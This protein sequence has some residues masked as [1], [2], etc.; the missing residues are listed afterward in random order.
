MP[1]L[2]HIPRGPASALMAATNMIATEIPRP[3]QSSRTA[4]RPAQTAPS[5]MSVA[6]TPYTQ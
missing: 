3:C 6:A 4:E 5:A 1:S 2:S